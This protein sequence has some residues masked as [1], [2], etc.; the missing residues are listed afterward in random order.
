MQQNDPIKD[1]FSGEEVPPNLDEMI[2]LFPDTII[3]KKN[4]SHYDVYTEDKRR[5]FVLNFEKRKCIEIH[6]WISHMPPSVR[7]KKISNEEEFSKLKGKLLSFLLHGLRKV[8][9]LA[10]WENYFVKT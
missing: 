7:M 5:S 6:I 1:F 3:E 10:K 4:L 9:E 2:S 8:P